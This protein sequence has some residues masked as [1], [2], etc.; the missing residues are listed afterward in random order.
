MSILS[1]SGIELNED[2][3]MKASILS[4][5]YMAARY[6]GYKQLEFGKETAEEAYRYAMEIVE[7]LDSIRTDKTEEQSV[8]S[9]SDD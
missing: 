3:L 8:K 4:G 6:P 1:D 7:F 2:I 5:Y 9:Q